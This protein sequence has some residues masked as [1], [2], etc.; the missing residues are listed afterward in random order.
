MRVKYSE[1]NPGVYI[2][3]RLTSHQEGGSD[4]YPDIHL[5]WSSL[6]TSLCRLEQRY[7]GLGFSLVLFSVLDKYFS[8]LQCPNL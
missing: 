6:V 8:V 3:S 2:L 7:V 4:L 1:C 5:D